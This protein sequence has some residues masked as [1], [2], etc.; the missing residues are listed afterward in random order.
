MSTLEVIGSLLTAVGTIAV[1]VLAIWGDW[2]RAIFA[3]AKLAIEPHNLVGDLTTFSDP[4]GLVFTGSRRVYF[5]HLKVVNRRPWVNPKNC[6]VLLKSISKRGPD[7]EFHPIPMSVPLQFTWAPAESTPTVVN[8]GDEAIFDFGRL[9]EHNPRFVPS[10]YSFSNNFLG[11]VGANEAIRYSL[12]VV[13]DTYISNIF[14]V[15]E[16][17]WDGKWD[18]HVD[19]MKMHLVIKE[20]AG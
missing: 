18:E 20:I 14:Q 5:Y 6:R 11:I 3:P 15:F 7:G 8:I 2:F 16:V 17:A 1:A 9:T 10:L 4:P 13:S 12:Q 19:K